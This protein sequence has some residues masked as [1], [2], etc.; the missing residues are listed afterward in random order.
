VRRPNFFI[1]GAPKSGTTALFE[2]LKSHPRI[3][4]SSEKEPHYFC[5]D[6]P[7]FRWAKSADQYLDYF[8]HATDAHLAVGEASPLYLYSRVAARN[9][10]AFA[11]DAKIVVMFRSYVDYLL[12]YHHH[13]VYNQDETVAR[14]EEAWHLQEERRA[15]KQIPSTCRE[16]AFLQYRDVASLGAQLARVY[17]AFPR[18]QVKVIFFDDFTRN[19]KAAYEDVLAFLG[20]PTDGRTEFPKVNEAKRHKNA[21]LGRIAKRPPKPLLALA[22]IVK[23]LIGLGKVSVLGK[24]RDLNTEQAKPQPLASEVAAEVR[25]SLRDDAKLLSELTGRDLRPW[26]E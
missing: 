18:E 4:V 14:F 16:P 8:R 17:E 24:L 19:T 13:T 23:P 21:L 11:P 15:G 9:I 5:E 20:V 25:A 22:R 10:K 2:Y 12:S 3:A 26:V 1:I 7:G 6:F